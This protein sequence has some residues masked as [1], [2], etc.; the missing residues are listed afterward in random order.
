LAVLPI[1]GVAPDLSP[2]PEALRWPATVMVLTAQPL[3]PLIVVLLEL[4]LRMP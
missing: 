3:E 1:L 4:M 2:A